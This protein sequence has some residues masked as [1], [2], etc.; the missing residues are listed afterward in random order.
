MLFITMAAAA[1]V[2]LLVLAVISMKLRKQETAGQ[3]VDP[4]DKRKEDL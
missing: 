1:G 2:V 3:A 4:S